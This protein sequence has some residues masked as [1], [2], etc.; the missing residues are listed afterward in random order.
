MALLPD[1]GDNT[2]TKRSQCL[3]AERPNEPEAQKRVLVMEK[4]IFWI[5]GCIRLALRGPGPGLDNMDTMVNSGKLAA[6]H[7]RGVKRSQESVRQKA[8][9]STNEFE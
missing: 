6:G 2:D 9:S 8:T 7:D 5:C 3:A 4:R 1:G